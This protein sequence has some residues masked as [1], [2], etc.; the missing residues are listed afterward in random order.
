VGVLFENLSFKEKGELL[1]IP[2]SGV[3][4]GK[5]VIQLILNFLFKE[6]HKVE[7]LNKLWL[8]KLTN[9]ILDEY[10]NYKKFNPKF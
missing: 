2:K 4:L 9:E 7:E 6:N 10:F 5:D 1:Q 3:V 8:F